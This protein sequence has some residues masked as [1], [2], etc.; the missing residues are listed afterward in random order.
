MGLFKKQ[1]PKAKPGKTA[2]AAKTDKAAAK[3]AKPKK[4]KQKKTKAPGPHSGGFW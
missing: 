2:A 4:A 3:A 1:T